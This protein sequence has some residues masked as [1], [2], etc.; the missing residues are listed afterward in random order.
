MSKFAKLKPEQ[1]FEKV[2]EGLRAVKGTMSD[3]EFN[4]LAQTLLGA[5]A[6]QEFGNIF[7]MTDAQY[8][9][10]MA[11]GEYY[12]TSEEIMENAGGLA[13]K[14]SEVT[15]AW[16]NFVT[17]FIG[18]E[19]FETITGF[20][21]NIIDLINSVTNAV[22][23]D[24]SL[25]GWLTGVD[26]GGMN[27]V[28]KVGEEYNKDLAQ[29]EINA[30]RANVLVGILADLEKE[31]G[32]LAK[33]TDTWKAAMAELEGI[34]PN[35]TE[36]INENNG[37]FLTGAENIRDYI[38]AQKELAI[39]E[40][41]QKALQN[42]SDAY[43]TELGI[44]YEYQAR[45]YAA[46]SEMETIARALGYT[47]N[48]GEFAF[49]GTQQAYTGEYENFNVQ[50]FFE[51]AGKLNKL[52]LQGAVGLTG[53]QEGALNMIHLTELNE[54]YAQAT[55]SVR[56]QQEAVDAALKSYED[57]AQLIETTVNSAMTGAGD[58]ATALGT[59]AANAAEKINNLSFT[60]K[61][62]GYANGLWNVPY[63]NYTASLHQ[64]EAV[65]TR[66]EAERWRN[67]QGGGGYIDAAATLNIGTFN[68]YGA[69]D[70]KTL[71]AALV[72]EQRNQLRAAGE[73]V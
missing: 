3:S 41:K 1:Q 7:E 58:G 17:N 29:A 23:S 11:S 21:Q 32:P 19:G 55:A 53:D 40:A 5:R 37:S 30:D 47:G 45:Q 31:M 8:A 72:S 46:Q 67:G 50:D 9:E 73:K 35:I 60:P 42:Y 26:D 28:N 10:F 49:G 14:F 6:F 27:R 34:Y 2:V 65:L 12:A 70:E 18:V 61:A 64:G 54:Q 66:I 39:V 24:I 38:S 69:S 51:W 15:T 43:T 33:D 52:N 36:V 68:S 63:D 13:D 48:N 59:A 71:V 4:V 57:M 22:T 20:I 16:Q 62:Y 44:L 56:K 25:W